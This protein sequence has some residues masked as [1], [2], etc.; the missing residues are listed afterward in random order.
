MAV[1]NLRIPRV[2]AWL[3]LVSYSV[4][5]LHPL[6]F[7]A[8]RDIRPLH[9]QHSAGA[10]LLLGAGCV[11]VILAASAAA[12]YGIEKPM[13]KLGRTVAKRLAT[14]QK[15]SSVKDQGFQQLI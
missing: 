5:L 8:F 11:A 9:R 12:Y 13:Q 6:V 3:G 10:Q 7:D 14:G 4:Y 1:R 2:L 15:P